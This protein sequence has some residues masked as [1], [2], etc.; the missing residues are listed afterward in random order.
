MD[1]QAFPVSYLR[2]IVDRFEIEGAVAQLQPFGGG[3]INDSFRVVNTR[4][5]CPD[6]LIQ[7]INHEVFRNVEGMMQNMHRVIHH[8][9]AKRPGKEVLQL[10][11]ALNG[12]AF[13]QVQGTFWRL[14][15]FKKDTKTYDVVQTPEQ[16][17]AGG[18]AFGDFLKAMGDFDAH[19]LTETIP[20]F[21]NVIFRIRQLE[22][23]VL[24]AVPDRL[25]QS[26]ALIRK[27][28]E[29]ADH[30][31]VVERQKQSGQIPIRVTHND[32]KF[33]NVLLDASD[34]AVCVIDLDTVMP[35]VVHYDYGDGI[36]TSTNLAA[37]DEPDLSNVRF[38]LQ[39][40]QAFTEGYL[41]GVN[42]MLTDAELKLFPLAGALMA[43]MMGI[44]FLADFLLG[45]R[46]YKTRVPDQNFHRAGCQL[47][48]V[49]QIVERQL[50]LAKYF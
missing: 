15:D 29:M 12:D 17:F 20:D 33:N 39:R 31:S 43:Y 8:L 6:Y 42:G 16:A 5:D 50:E 23:A 3:H 7:R 19:Q 48:L 38:D 25:K 21:H 30:M 34:Q 1:K 18:W 27:A 40:F 11:P 14:V 46:Y 44:R 32:T 26:R 24:L 37:E 2:S 47:E 9:Q 45:D 49:G 22:D 41:E 10:I 28:R 36:R 35:G 4:N 13:I